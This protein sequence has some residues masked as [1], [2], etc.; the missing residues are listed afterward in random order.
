MI[1][2]LALLPSVTAATSEVAAELETI[3][4]THKLPALGCLVVRSNGVVAL[5]VVGVRKAGTPAPALP[6]DQWHLGSLT[7]SLTATLAAVLVEAGKISWTNTLADV[8]PEEA[9]GMH[10]AWR[11]VTLE[12]LLAHR[13]GGPDHDWLNQQGIWPKVWRRNSPND[14]AGTRRWFLREVTS[15]EPQQP[16]NGEYVYSNAGYMLAGAMLEARTGESWETLM[17]RRVF[18]PLGMT[19]AGFGP[20]KSGQDV[21]QP[22]G[23]RAKLP[24]L[25]VTPVG[26]DAAADNPVALGP[27]GTVHASLGDMAR[28]LQAHLDGALG[29]PTPLKLAP[30]TWRRLHTPR[31]GESYALGWSVTQRGWAGGTALNHTGSNTMW[32]ANLWLAPAREFA[33]LIV[34]N[35]DGGTAFQATDE[36][37]AAMILRFLRK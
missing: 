22:V 34:T 11:D 6:S 1:A 17:R 18:E 35:A 7:K 30:D 27:A 32:Y 9:A 16:P 19:N 10:A 14:V 12:R 21:N 24:L 15:R 20:P 28:Y 23:H 37:A 29:R 25:P 3:R 5:E 26:D 13:G 8:F 31:P 4:S 2:L 33:V 36:V